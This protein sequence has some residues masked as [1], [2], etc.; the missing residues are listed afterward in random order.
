MA[1]RSFWN[2]EPVVPPFIPQLLLSPFYR[3][4]LVAD[5]KASRI[6]KGALAIAR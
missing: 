3:E 4:H 1:A 2:R 6:G 5:I